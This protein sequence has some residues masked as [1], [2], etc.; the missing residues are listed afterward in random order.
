MMMNIKDRIIRFID[1]AIKK[2]GNPPTLREIGKRFGISHVAAG[3]HI[4]KLEKEGRI[5]TRIAVK[6]R[7]SRSIKILKKFTND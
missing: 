1:K 5:K 3:Y 4:T 2:R 6:K 7:A